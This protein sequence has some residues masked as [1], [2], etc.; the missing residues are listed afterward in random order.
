MINK[1]IIVNLFRDGGYLWLG[2][3]AI[4]EAGFKEGALYYQTWEDNKVTFTLDKPD[5]PLVKTRKVNMHK[6]GAVIRAEG[7][8]VRDAFNGYKSVKATI[9]PG[10]IVV[11]G[12]EPTSMTKEVLPDPAGVALAL[13]GR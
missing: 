7:T 1:E 2:H 3:K 11:T 10:R 5:A 13:A 8:P 6:H 12:H 4:E 9:S